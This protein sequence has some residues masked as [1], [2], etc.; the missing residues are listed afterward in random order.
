MALWRDPLD[1]LIEGIEQVIPQETCP[2][3]WSIPSFTDV[4]FAI[5]PLLDLTGDE[6]A[7]PPQDPRVKA[8]WR[9]F[10]GLAQRQESSKCP[11]A[12]REPA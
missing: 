5:A 9:W 8:V 10:E 2:A 1:E 11:S 12:P 7:R 3:D 6:Q 4:Q